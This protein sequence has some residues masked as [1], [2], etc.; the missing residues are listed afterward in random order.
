M[1]SSVTSR[2]SMSMASGVGIQPMGLSSASALPLTRS[3]TH[4]STR[5][6][7]P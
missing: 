5:E 7:S 4:S 6:L 2:P 3:K 1:S